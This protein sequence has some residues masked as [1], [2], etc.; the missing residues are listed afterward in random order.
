MS[1]TE[2]RFTLGSMVGQW[3]P[4]RLRWCHPHQKRKS[5]TEASV[6]PS[7]GKGLASC[8]GRGLSAI[9]DMD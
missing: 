2:N 7:G 3:H 5:T 9:A 6:P 8:A 1:E 4:A